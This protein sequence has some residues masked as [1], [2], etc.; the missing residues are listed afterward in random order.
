MKNIGLLVAMA[1]TLNCSGG[2]SGNNSGTIPYGGD[3][4]NFGGGVGNES[5]NVDNE[6][7]LAALKALEDTGAIP[8]LERTDTVQGV[9]IGMNGIRDDVEEYVV[10]HYNVPTQQ[11]AALQFATSVQLALLVDTTD[12][13]S[14]QNASK[15]MVS[16]V[17][18]I[19]ARFDTGI[20]PETVV[21]EVRSISTNTKIRLL[22]YLAFGS[23]LDGTVMTLPEGDSCE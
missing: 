18:C 10:A 3:G 5:E 4:G 2:N 16:A 9:D 12:S 8:K 22:A 20:E 21:S 11:K 23:A 19:Y 17:S 1:L 7:A 14:V 15:K 6:A 13:E